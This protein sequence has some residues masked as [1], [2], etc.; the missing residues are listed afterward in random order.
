MESLKSC[1]RIWMTV[2]HQKLPPWRLPTL[3]RIDHDGLGEVDVHEPSTA[4]DPS[5]SDQSAMA[6]TLVE[7]NVSPDPTLLPSQD[8]SI[9]IPDPEEAFEDV[10]KSKKDKKKRKKAKQVLTFEEEAD[11]K[12]VEDDMVRDME[13]EGD[14][15]SEQTLPGEKPYL[16]P[17]IFEDQVRDPVE[18]PFEDTFSSKKSKKKG[19]KDRSSA[20]TEDDSGIN[21]PEQ[22]QEI[23]LKSDSQPVERMREGD[24]AENTANLDAIALKSGQSQETSEPKESADFTQ[25][26]QPE[27]LTES[28]AEPIADFA[29]SDEAPFTI[30]KKDSK[31]EKKAKRRLAED[32]PLPEI[33]PLV[34]HSLSE[35]PE[36][37]VDESAEPHPNEVTIEGIEDTETIK[38]K[39]DKKKKRKQGK[40][41]FGQEDPFADSTEVSAT[42][43]TAVEELEVPSMDT[44]S[45]PSNEA[46]VQ[47]ADGDAPGAVDETFPMDPP[48]GKKKKSKKSKLAMSEEPALNPDIPTAS[49]EIA[50][51]D[52]TIM[53][54]SPQLAAETMADNLEQETAIEGDEA[55]ELSMSAKTRKDK[56]KGKKKKALIWDE[57]LE[58]PR[59]E[60]AEQAQS[61]EVDEGPSQEPAIP[62]ELPSDPVQE[63]P[64]ALDE[65]AAE[66]I[67]PTDA[68]SGPLER[69]LVG[70]EAPTP[71]S[72]EFFLPVTGPMTLSEEPHLTC[73]RA[74]LTCRRAHLTCRRALHTAR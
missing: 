61:V 35:A 64:Q 29:Q 3:L 23:I 19:K 73:R 53:K 43:P 4:P 36:N 1:Y 7:R 13:V 60:S 71:P 41:I 62:D 45:E 42:P 28:L 14:R 57:P 66:A 8:P 47:A 72:E 37:L 44:P 46:A 26:G 67:V 34:P 63:T 25:D 65:H 59:D 9:S 17:A 20:L 31:K 21:T 48:K 11:D 22:F 10:V 52:S 38:G 50:A 16:S 6:P 18:G 12:P 55:P 68:S 56:K 33:A 30:S 2:T 54:N 5:L 27:I 69:S 40:Q 70:S 49:D 58:I 24:V 32:Q 74:H 39:R 51:A 15:A